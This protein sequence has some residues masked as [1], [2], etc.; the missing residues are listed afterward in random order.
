MADDPTPVDEASTDTTGGAAA[1][2]DEMT[3]R[4]SRPAPEPSPPSDL[5]EPDPEALA[6]S[7]DDLGNEGLQSGEYA[8][9]AP[10][11]TELRPVR[12]DSRGGTPVTVFGAGFVPG[13]KVFVGEEELIAEAKDAFTLRFVAPAGK[14]SASVIV[15]APSGKRSPGSAILAFV[16]GPTIVRAKPEEGPT[17]GG[18]EVVLEGSG[19]TDGCTVSLFGAHAPDVVFESATRLRFT[20]PAAGDGP[21]DG[22]ITVTA[23]DGLMGR[24]DDVF[25]YRPLKPDILEIE[26]SHGWVSGGKM[27]ALKGLD[28][29]ERCK[30]IVAGV[31]AVTHFRTSGH[32]DFEV[33]PREGEGTVEVQLL[34]PDKRAALISFE[35]RPVPA[36]PK[37]IELLPNSGLTTGGYNVRISGDNFTDDVRVR[38][39]ELTC[40]RKV[41]SSKL[42]DI[43]VPARQLPG[44]VALE[45][46]LDEYNI[47]LEEAFTYASPRAP[48]ITSLEPR[49]GPTSGGTRVVIEGDHFPKS[50]SVR[51]GDEPA[52]S[53]AVKSSTRL[54][55]VTPPTRSAG[56][57][58]VV[59]TSIETGPGVAS[60]GFRYETT[61]P[62]TITVVSPQKGTIDGGT[63]LSIEGKNFAEG[64]VVL[65]GGLP[66]K[67]K[68]ISGSVLEAYTPGGDDGKMV[69]VTVKNPDGQQAIQKRAF[70]Y[71]AR[72]RS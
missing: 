23:L 72:Y 25:R 65:V 38:L 43:D 9:A 2:L 66:A 18:I 10:V 61:P 42:I 8:P 50:C 35:Y 67:T 24:A 32:V 47:R 52:K 53:V 48:K 13:C 33:P 45:V 34:N 17:E 39:G 37:I 29:H 63:E 21:L 26:P 46:I 71:D 55:V 59:V 28:F 58:D 5:D 40:T 68:R 3:M 62:P 54:E 60:K 69:D 16:E 31:P 27:I 11:I 30:V 14:G 19:F 49:S 57:I 41:V 7:P 56:L 1:G 51:F 22:A 64:V 12:V 36:P 70:Q 6:D 15:E 44:T 20:L 4:P